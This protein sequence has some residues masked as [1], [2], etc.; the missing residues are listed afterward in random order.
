MAMDDPYR[1]PPPVSEPR[2]EEPP[3]SLGDQIYDWFLIALLVGI[4]LCLGWSVFGDG[5]RV[6]SGLVRDLTRF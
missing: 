2:H 4:H 6:L 1:T 3:K 5:I